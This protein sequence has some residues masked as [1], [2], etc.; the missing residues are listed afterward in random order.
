MSTNSYF[1]HNTSVN[2]RALVDKLVVE[3]IQIAGLDIQYLPR[4]N[5][6]IDD[7]DLL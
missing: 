7:I 6:N 3:S 5:L 4:T 2:E 1:T